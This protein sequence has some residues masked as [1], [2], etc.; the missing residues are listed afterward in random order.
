MKI[1]I[2]E[3]EKPLSDSMVEYLSEEGHLC[4]AIYNYSDAIEK[5]GLYQYDCLCWLCCC[6]CAF[7][8]NIV[9]V[10]I[11]VF[12]VVV[13]N[14]VAGIAFVVNVIVVGAF[15]VDVYILVF[16]VVVAS[17]ADI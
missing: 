17:V 14:V 6:C 8:A 10:N 16:N 1:L 12:N 3:D 5:I 4:E 2:V 9:D 11:L 13:V 7:V 15:V